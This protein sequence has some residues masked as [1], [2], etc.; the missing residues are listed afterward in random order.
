M[1]EHGHPIPLEY[2]GA[3]VPTQMNELG[4]AGA[5]G[6][7][8]WFNPDSK[9]IADR[10]EEIEHRNAIEKKEMFERL[11]EANRREIEGDDK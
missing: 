3:R 7:G 11:Q 8:G 9:D 2:Q 6:R 5:P 10:A 4:A 1:D